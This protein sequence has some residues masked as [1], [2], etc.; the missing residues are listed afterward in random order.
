MVEKKNIIVTLISI[1]LA[2][3][4]E[5]NVLLDVVEDKDYFVLKVNNQTK[6]EFCFYDNIVDQLR[7]FPKNSKLLPVIEEPLLIDHL[8]CPF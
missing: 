7:F 6:N 2:S 8:T 4:S 5:A 1:L 3:C